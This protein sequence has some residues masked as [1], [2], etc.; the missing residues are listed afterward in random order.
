MAPSEPVQEKAVTMPN[1]SGTHADAVGSPLKQK[2]LRRIRVGY[3]VQGA[4][5]PMESS[6]T[7]PN[8]QWDLAR[9]QNVHCNI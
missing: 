6:E 2:G 5:R 3:A 1:A 4:Q 8:A 9:S 7:G